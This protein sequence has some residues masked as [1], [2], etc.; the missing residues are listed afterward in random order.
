LLFVIAIAYFGLR[1]RA[2]VAVELRGKT[3]GTTYLVRCSDIA[4]TTGLQAAIDAVL[5]DVNARMSTYDPQSELARFNRAGT[6]A[7]TPLSPP[8]LELLTLAHQVSAASDGAFD[9]TVGPLVNA[10]G[11][12]KDGERSP[13][14]EAELA[15]LR[16]RVGYRL[17]TIDR[18]A[19]TV[20][21]AVA[22]L[23]IDLSAI[24]KG[25]GV[26]LVA[27]ALEARGIVD[28]M[29]EIGGEV[30]VRGHNAQGQPWRIGIE[31]PQLA[32][33]LDSQVE[34]VLHLRAGALATSGDYRNYRD[35][36]GKRITHL[37]DPRT[38]QPITH[39][40]AAVTVVADTC[41]LADA[42]ATALMVL[43]PQQAEATA[44]ER[45]LA[46]L[47]QIREPNG[48]WRVLTTQA[49]DAWSHHQG[50]PVET[51]R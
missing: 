12:G 24:A 42:W 49:F 14:D 13:P 9:V 26:D 38:A 5:R 45:G 16:Q 39:T 22:E 36:G 46:A 48:T 51:P 33:A 2:A 31:H 30:R 6:I 17:L 10:F 19:G 50:P 11:F 47:L 15:S 29:V 3:M 8:L 18:T 35:V 25:Y 34:R 43:G 21:R 37:I 41:A 44:R 20:T 28:Y 4:D 40:L 23:E 32:G 27:R 1:Q 7:P